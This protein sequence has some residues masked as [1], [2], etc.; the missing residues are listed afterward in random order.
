M[1][2]IWLGP[3]ERWG[4]PVEHGIESRNLVHSH[5]WHR[6]KFSD[7]IHDADA[8]PSLILP[9]C[10]VKQRN[11]GR[12]LVLRWVVGND[13]V[14]PCEVV[15]SE[16][17]GNLN[18]KHLVSRMSEQMRK[19]GVN[20]WVV[21]RGVPMLSNRKVSVCVGESGAKSGLRR[22]WRRK[23]WRRSLRT[24][25]RRTDGWWRQQAAWRILCTSR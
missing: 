8:C 14:G 23:T 3:R 16:L 20:L 5:G 1:L 12:F 7:V 17:E 21:V 19:D 15:G 4:I 25:E 2:S 6:K 10:K 11:D 22:K 18:A 24:S 9:L 13:L